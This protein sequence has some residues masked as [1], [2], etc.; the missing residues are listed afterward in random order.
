MVKLVSGLLGSKLG[1]W[2]YLL[3]L[4]IFYMIYKSFTKREV[5]KITEYLPDLNSTMPQKVVEDIVKKL[6]FAMDRLGT[7]E[8]LIFSQFK[9]INS[10]YDYNRVSNKFGVVPYKWGF[11]DDGWGGRNLNLQEVLKAELSYPE[12]KRLKIIA[13]YLSSYKT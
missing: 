3:I 8:E 2:Q 10:V 6:H 13:P 1:N 11:F 9:R 4:P 5:V 7:D 12:Y